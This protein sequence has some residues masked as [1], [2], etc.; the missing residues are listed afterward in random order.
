MAQDCL[1]R[2]RLKRSREELAALEASLPTLTG[3]EKINAL[4]R[5]QQLMAQISKYT[6]HRS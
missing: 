4:Q 1:D 3:Q 5:A 6:A 2:N